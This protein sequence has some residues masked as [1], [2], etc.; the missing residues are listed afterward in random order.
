MLVLPTEQTLFEKTPKKKFPG[1]VNHPIRAMEDPIV[2][3]GKKE[4]K[5]EEGE[6]K[7]D[8]E[9]GNPHEKL[10]YASLVSPEVFRMKAFWLFDWFPDELIIEEKR[11]IIKQKQIP[12]FITTTTIPLDKLIVFQ[13][14]RSIFFSSIYI[15]GEKEKTE[16]EDYTISWLKHEDARM[17][18]ELI[19][20]LHMK[21]KEKVE[22]LDNS[23]RKKIQAL[24]VLG[25]MY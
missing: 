13:V 23:P 4:D 2:L 6:D 18:K 9:D 5:K 21:Q 16:V 1:K 25:N 20:G 10:T 3:I 8:E 19:D 15:K 7:K 17:A 11:L 12:F 14:T 24:Q 22:I